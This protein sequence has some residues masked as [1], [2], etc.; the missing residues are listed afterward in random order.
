MRYALADIASAHAMINRSKWATPEPGWDTCKYAMSRLTNAARLIQSTEGIE[1]VGG[2]WERGMPMS[3]E[4][5]S[6]TL[7]EVMTLLDQAG[8]FIDGLRV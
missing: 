6:E 7:R 3:T 8:N 4:A 1:M 5:T 2:T